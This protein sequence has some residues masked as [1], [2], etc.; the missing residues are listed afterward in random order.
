L[1]KDA[2]AVRMFVEEGHELFV[3]Q[4]FAKNMGLYSNILV[5]LLKA[6][7]LFTKYKI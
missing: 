5:L 6:R 3:A 1:D 4:S 7:L 2:A